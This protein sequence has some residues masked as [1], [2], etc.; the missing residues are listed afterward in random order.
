MR[1]TE[2]NFLKICLFL[3]LFILNSASVFAIDEITLENPQESVKMEVYENVET[4][5]IKNEPITSSENHHKTVQN[6]IHDVFE[7]KIEDNDH[8]E[9]LLDRGLTKHFENGPLDN[10]GIWGL[11]RGGI[12]ESFKKDDNHTNFNFNV[13]ETR[14]HG[15]FKDKKTSFVITTRFTPQKEFTFMQNLFSD[16]FIRHR[17]NEHAILTIGNTR[18]HTGQEGAMSEV[19]IPFYYRSQISRQ[20]GNIRKLGVR[21]AGDFKLMEYDVAYNTSGTYFTSFFPGSE[22]CGWVNFKPLGMTDG[23]YG[24]LKIGGG[25]TA[26]RRHFDYNVLGAYASYKYKKFMA[27][28]EIAQGNG[29][30]GRVGP[31]STH[32]NGFYTSLYYDLTKK[33]QLVARFD[34]FTPD[35]KNSEHKTREYSAGFNYFIK[36]QALKIILNYVFREDSIAG[37]S[38][39]IIIGTQVLL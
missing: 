30:N 24:V 21:L 1:I 4:D 38:H 14:L 22:F 16:L 35:T 39:R 29:S 27:D 8:I 19:L 31:V 13:L 10:L 2:K 5:E 23:K 25:L 26:G 12:V 37:N 20:Y 18:T 7:L 9:Y 6:R 17:F 32:T 15:E 11:W 3:A 34:Q 36:G 33:L 28:F